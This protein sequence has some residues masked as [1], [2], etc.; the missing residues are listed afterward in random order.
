ME[1]GWGGGVDLRRMFGRGIGVVWGRVG[2]RRLDGT[3][4]EEASRTEMWSGGSEGVRAGKKVGR[5]GGRWKR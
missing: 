1:W 4:L 3:I 5:E 2:G